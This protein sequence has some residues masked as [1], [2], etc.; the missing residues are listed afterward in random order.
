[1]NIQRIFLISLMIAIDL[2][3]SAFKPSSSSIPINHQIQPLAK[4]LLPQA[5]LR[6]GLF[7]HRDAAPLHMRPNESLE[8]HEPQVLWTLIRLNFNLVYPERHPR[9]LKHV[10]EISKSNYYLSQLSTNAEPFLHMIVN[11]V[12]RRDIPLEIALLPMIESNFEPKA[13]S[14]SGAGGLWQIMPATGR[15]LGLKQDHWYDGRKDV[16][17]ST[18]AALSH[19]QYLHRLFDEDWLLALAAYNCGER[20]VQNAIKQNKKLQKPTDFWHLS[21]PQETQNYVPKLLALA[22]IVKNPAKHNV[23]LPPIY[24]ETY[25]EVVQ[26]NHQIDL[27]IAADL[28]KIKHEELLLLNPGLQQ[29]STHPKGPH[30]LLVP[31][32]AAPILTKQLR[33]L[34]A[35]DLTMHHTYIVKKGDNLNTIAQQCN[36]TVSALHMIN[37]LSSNKVYPGTMIYIPNKNSKGIIPTQELTYV[38]VRGDSLWSISQEHKVKVSELISWN[39]LD[40]QSIKPGQKLIIYKA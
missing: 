22:S 4:W 32:A 27:K 20:R 34:N 1:M 38:V 5:G 7:S 29:N 2:S 11:E 23:V 6:V 21:L 15:I 19:L 30:Q 3:L 14:R 12:Q 24:N 40:R 17:K 35:S 10:K 8:P 36:T 28:A 31:A 39:D 37:D 16:K 26:V 33:R 18:I 25:L 9:V 13:I